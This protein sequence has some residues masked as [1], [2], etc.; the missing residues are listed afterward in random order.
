LF[1]RVSVDFANRNVRFLLR[2]E[3][4]RDD[5]RYAETHLPRNPAA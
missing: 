3:A 1:D 5:R 2:D 4:R